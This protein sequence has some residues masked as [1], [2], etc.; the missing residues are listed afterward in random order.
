MK[1]D[2]IRLS[3]AGLF[4]VG[5]H[6]IPP[7]IIVIENNYHQDYNQCCLIKLLAGGNSIDLHGCASSKLINNI[8]S[9]NFYLIMLS[10]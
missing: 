4:R 9:L 3:A 5:V 2:R 10:I 8:L 6:L 7:V 1:E